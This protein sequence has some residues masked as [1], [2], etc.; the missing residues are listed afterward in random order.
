MNIRSICGTHAKPFDLGIPPTDPSPTRRP[1]EKLEFVEHVLGV[2]IE[3]RF[4][5][6]NPYMRLGEPT[7][8]T[9][10]SQMFANATLLTEA[11]IEIRLQ[12]AEFD[13]TPFYAGLLR[14]LPLGLANG[15]AARWIGL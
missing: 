11:E 6:A 14:E 15:A 12:G 9:G 4:G 13:R 8:T 1:G 7:V 3:S 2:L 5:S 10:H